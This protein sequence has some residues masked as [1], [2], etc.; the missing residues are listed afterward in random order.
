MNMPDGIALNYNGYVKNCTVKKSPRRQSIVISVLFSTAHC[1][2]GF[3][4]LFKIVDEKSI[5]GCWL[6]SAGYV[7]MQ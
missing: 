3:L 4:G 2:N 7:A 6:K 1:S 5:R